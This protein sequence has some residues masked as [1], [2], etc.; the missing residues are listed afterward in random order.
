MKICMRFG[1]R[2]E[3][4]NTLLFV[5]D[6]SGNLVQLDIE[7]LAMYTSLANTLT[8]ID[9][10]FAGEQVSAHQASAGDVW[11]VAPNVFLARKLFSVPK[12]ISQFPG[13]GNYQ[14]G[15][16]TDS[17]GDV[18]QM[19]VFGKIVGIGRLD[20]YQSGDL[21]FQGVRATSLGDGLGVEAWGNFNG[22]ALG[23]GFITPG[24]NILEG[25][26][27]VKMPSAARKPA[28]REKH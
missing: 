12:V 8:V 23:A 26:D 28:S 24:L 3:C 4:G 15:D 2:Q 17:N 5:S 25:T 7:K 21:I 11:M 18:T 16:V 20:G 27:G 9:R 19:C 22:V 1:R 6:S 13:Y 10:D 14:S